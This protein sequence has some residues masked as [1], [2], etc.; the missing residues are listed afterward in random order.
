VLEDAFD[1]V[2]IGDVGDLPVDRG[3]EIENAPG[4]FFLTA[5]LAD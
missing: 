5:S 4:Y 2:R 1:E 3:G